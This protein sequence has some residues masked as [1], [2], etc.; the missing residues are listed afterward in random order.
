L[1]INGII[2]G[3]HVKHCI[4]AGNAK[5][6]YLVG[7]RSIKEKGNHYPNPEIVADDLMTG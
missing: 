1:L 7:H 5:L 2:K 3:L 6:K 4:D